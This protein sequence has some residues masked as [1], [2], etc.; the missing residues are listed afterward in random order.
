[1]CDNGSV[2][3]CVSRCSQTRVFENESDVSGQRG[4]VCVRMDL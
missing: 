4:D 2:G 3:L 1:M